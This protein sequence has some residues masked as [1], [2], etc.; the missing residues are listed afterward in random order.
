MGEKCNIFWKDEPR[1][2]IVVAKPEGWG[3]TWKKSSR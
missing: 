1:I 2:K 3:L